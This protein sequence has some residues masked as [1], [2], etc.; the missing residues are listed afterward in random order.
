MQE[1][2]LPNPYPYPSYPYPKNTR[3]YPY[4]CLALNS[5]RRTIRLWKHTW[6][7]MKV[8]RRIGLL[9]NLTLNVLLN[10]W[11]VT[12]FSF[13][14]FVDLLSYF[15]L[16]VM[17]FYILVLSLINIHLFI[18]ISLFLA[19]EQILITVPHCLSYI[20]MQ[21]LSPL[22]LLPCNMMLC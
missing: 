8:G 6:C 9:S 15:Q 11:I 10:G 17:V 13:H 12:N 16:V 4:P 20:V 2:E 18:E 5:F 22:L 21:H 3:V 7:W 19:S 1:Y 14:S